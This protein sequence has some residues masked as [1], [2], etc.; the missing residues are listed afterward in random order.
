VKARRFSLESL[1]AERLRRHLLQMSTAKVR[2]Q[3]LI[4]AA[5]L[6]LE[7]GLPDAGGALYG[8]VFLNV[9]FGATGAALRSEVDERT[10][11]WGLPRVSAASPLGGF[12]VDVAVTEL[13]RLIAYDVEAPSGPDMSSLLVDDGARSVQDQRRMLQTASRLAAVLRH[14]PRLQVQG[15][16]ADAFRAE[17]ASV[18]AIPY[19]EI[20]SYVDQPLETLIAIFLLSQARHFLF[21]QRESLFAKPSEL[22]ESAAV[23]DPA[24]LGP[25]FSHV[26]L[27][28]RDAAD[29][30]GLIAAASDLPL[31]PRR[32]ETWVILLSSGFDLEGL[33][34]LVKE[35]AGQGMVSALRAILARLVLDRWTSQSSAVVRQLRDS[36]LYAPD[37]AIEAQQ[38]I[39]HRS[40]PSDV[41]HL[42]LGDLLQR[43]G[44]IER[45]EAAYRR[46][47]SLGAPASVVQARLIEL[48]AKTLNGV[49]ERPQDLP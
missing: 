10:N 16:L 40:P 32:L 41:E 33:Q 44:A 21:R 5:E 20:E 26:P 19:P 37:L 29:L 22:F 17:F 46:A 38:L 24:A 30:V 3:D 35:L 2:V 43:A 18:M 15:G 42:I 48:K 12:S 11:L 6:A 28:L 23:L 7:V 31:E 8:L 36:V 45:A 34:P 27:L 49:V 25:F 47:S 14:A 39:L 13:R 1:T 4:D 9:G